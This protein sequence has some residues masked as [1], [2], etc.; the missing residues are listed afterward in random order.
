M[1]TPQPHYK[2]APITEAIIDFKVRWRDGIDINAFRDIHPQIE[3]QFPQSE[4]IQTNSIIIEPGP[5]RKI[6]TTEQDIGYKFTSDNQV[7]IFQAT[8]EGFT[9]NHLTPYDSWEPFRD[10]AKRLWDIYRNISPSLYVTRLALRYVN[11]VEIPGPLIDYDDYFLTFPRIGASLPQVLSNFFMQLHIP[12]EDLNGT[13]IINEA[14]SPSDSQNTIAVILDFDVF[15]VGQW[16]SDDDAGI[17][18]LL[19]E[20][21]TRKNQAFEASIT[22]A[23]RRLFD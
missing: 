13:L 11:R 4:L 6:E 8:I 21:R 7:R 12:Q 23:T 18:G 9:F 2:K 10:E 20:L 22:E 16:S 14:Y 3:D 17:W 1:Q 5:N 15:C 19:E